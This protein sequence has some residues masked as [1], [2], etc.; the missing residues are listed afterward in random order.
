MILRSDKSETS[1][2][3]TG[4]ND[5]VSRCHCHVR[6]TQNDSDVVCY[7]AAPNSILELLLVTPKLLLS[8]V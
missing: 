1:G 6:L 5:P 4:S 2:R 8:E 7:E 3:F